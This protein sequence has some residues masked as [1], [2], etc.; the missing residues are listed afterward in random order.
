MI[1]RVLAGLLLCTSG[2]VVAEQYQVLGIYPWSD[3]GALSMYQDGQGQLISM[4]V[5][6]N[7]R[8]NERGN[9]TMLFNYMHPQFSESDR[10][11][12]GQG[13]YPKTALID[14]QTVNGNSYCVSGNAMTFVPT[15]DDIGY[16]V[17]RFSLPNHRV[18]V[19]FA[20]AAFQITTEGFEQQG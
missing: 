8:E 20:G 9:T 6:F 7:L 12:F 16:V 17:E 18:Y 13:A 14:G 19:N 5:S 11:G 4:E 3:G 10:C 1:K 2:T 15:Q